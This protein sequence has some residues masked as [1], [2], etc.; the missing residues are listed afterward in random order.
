[1]W[2]TFLLDLRFGTRLLTKDRTFSATVLLTLAV[3]IGAN[4]AIFSIV[5][6]VLLKPLPVP[7]AERLVDVYNSYPNAGAPIASSGVPDYYDR[8]R[9]MTAVENLSLYRREGM[10]L[11]SEGG[12]ERLM[13]VRATPSFYH[14]L[15]VRPLLGRIF[16]DDE[17]EPGREHVVILSY[18]AWKARFGGDPSIVGRTIRLSGVPYEVVGVMPAD[19]KFLWND[20]DFWTPAAFT[21][22]QKSDDARHSNNWNSIGMLKPGATLALAQEQLDAIN[23]RNDARFPQFH[24]IL[25]DAGFTTRV[26]NLQSMVVRDIQP[27][28]YLLWAGVL[29]VLLI[30]CVNIANLVV[31]RAS[32]RKRELATRQALGAGFGRLARQLLTETTLLAAAGGAL[33]LLGGWWALRSVPALHLDDL[34]RGHE[35]GLDPVSVAVTF[36]LA[37]GVGLAVGLVPVVRLA[38]LNVNTALREEGRGGTSGRGAAFLRRALATAQVAIAFVLLVG[39][40]LMLASFEAVLHLN[41]GFESANVATA[42]ISLPSSTYKDDAADV[43]FVDRALEAVRSLPGVES[44]GVTTQ[45][46]FSG[47]HNDSVILAEGY[48][49]KPGESLISPRNSSVSPGYF[50]ALHIPL[51]RGRYFDARDTAD[52]PGT[53]IVDERLAAKFWPGRDPLG[54]RMYFPSSAKD[55]LAV[56]PDTKF[57]TVVGVVSNVEMEGPGGPFLPVGAYY[58]PY[59]QQPQHS[60]V[61]T[62][63]T[64]GD[65]M[66]LI[67]QVRRKIAGIDPELPLF[68][69]KT[70]DARVDNGLVSRRVP[71]LVAMAFGIV[72]LFLAALGIYGVLAYGVSQRRREIGIRMALGSS[73]REVFGLVV[74]DGVRMIVAGF[75]FGLAGAYLAGR[76]M[77]SLLFGV[78]P[79]DPTVFVGVIGVLAVVGLVST[80]VPARRAA[81]V[82]PL[83]A[84][85]DQ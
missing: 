60:F 40:G 53:I 55:I 84:L 27:V 75:A 31:V 18:G 57:Y 7:N 46:P 45:L 65:P 50:E 2:R 10:T 80:V 59:P 5:R 26:V 6:S 85:S 71:M 77:T 21:P 23:R 76:A 17:G 49:M 48:T 22:E 64:A 43:A 39:A 16:T 11:G 54:R 34:P 4:A 74:G 32:G 81:H 41:P 28:L 70:M 44:A 67:G 63:K 66:S 69:V 73:T 29:F 58:F 51:V 13:S 52:A 25:K 20:V 30:G 62:V 19:F 56:G 8:V 61:L 47:D 79:L 12:A 14:L 83:V 33:G 38:K 3:C 72:A 35:I 24:Q 42:A 1:M 68:D 82:S 36:G 15:S 78:Q 37:I 9:D